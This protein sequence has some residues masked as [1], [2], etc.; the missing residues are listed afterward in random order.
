MLEQFLKAGAL[1]QM[2]FTLCAG[3]PL[4][5]CL[6][7]HPGVG[8]EERERMLDEFGERVEMFQFAGGEG[9][10]GLDVVQLIE[11]CTESGGEVN[12]GASATVVVFV[13]RQQ[14]TN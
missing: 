3:K 12:G 9:L 7:H 13:P 5:D 11:P 4:I 8:E 14:V 10:S 6:R 1:D 2:H